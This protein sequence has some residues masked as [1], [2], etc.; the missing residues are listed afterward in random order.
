MANRR[1]WF[2]RL[3]KTSKPQVEPESVIS[4]YFD[5]VAQYRRASQA[6]PETGDVFW[7]RLQTR[8]LLIELALKTYLCASGEIV[9]GHNLER[10][11][12]RAKNRGLILTEEDWESLIT[13]T[14]KIYFRHRDWNANY[15][16]RYPTPNRG[17]AVWI[18]P[19]HPLLDQMVQRIIDQA[20]FAWT[21]RSEST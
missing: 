19:L 12:R 15:L 2:S 14:N 6:M 9:R 18:T 1:P 17:L 7:P 20:H 11:A 10:L 4:D 8:G 13:K 16:S 21:K 3:C 5:Y